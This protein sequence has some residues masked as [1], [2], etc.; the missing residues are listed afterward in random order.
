MSH[1]SRYVAL[2]GAS[3]L[4]T[5]VACAD[6]VEVLVWHT[7]N[8][9]NAAEFKKLADQFNKEQSE[10]KVVA[11]VFP[12]QAAMLSPQARQDAEKRKPDLIQLDD[13]HSPEIVSQHKEIVPL[14]Q[15]LKQYPIADLGWYLPQTTGFVRDSKNQLLAFPFMA[16]IPVMFYNLDAYRKAGLNPSQPAA[17]WTDLQ[18]HLLA[19][20]DKADFD[21][22]YATSQE[23]LV[24]FESLAPINNSL[25][26][27]PNNGLDNAKG[28]MLN[29]DTVYMRH[30][31][32]MVSWKKSLLFT[33]YSNGNEPDKLYAEGKCSVLTSGSG[34]LGQLQA[35]KGLK[36]GIAPLPYHPLATSKPGAPFVTGSALWATAGHTKEQN[37]AMMGFLAF[38]SKPVLAAQW[39]QRTGY[40]PLTDAAY[41]SA[42]VAFYDSVPGA[43][44]VVEMM[45]RT[46]EKNQRGFRLPN[47]AKVEQILVREFDA[48]LMDKTPPIAALNIAMDEAKPLLQQGEAPAKPAP[49]ARKK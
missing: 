10:V 40:L 15:L 32:I 30:M 5:G 20:R 14:Y 8:P 21:C 16:E 26:A 19:L 46:P 41:R 18:A 29:F 17:T 42:D 36:T 28:L 37:K 39:H 48:A 1:S 25:Y 7:L 35:T 45:K 22:P 27:T 23:V 43:R 3:L 11:R 49:A 12:N 38:L 2:F 4:C 44:Q 34:S 47:Y 9:H 33:T 24:H 13:N 31:A 6:P